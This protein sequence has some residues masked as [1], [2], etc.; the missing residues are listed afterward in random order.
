MFKLTIFLFKLDTDFYYIS[1]LSF[2][3]AL[4]AVN[5]EFDPQL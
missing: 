4:S 5:R 1:Q 2:A 3:I